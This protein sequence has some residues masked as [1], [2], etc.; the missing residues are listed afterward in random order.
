MIFSSFAS[1]IDMKGKRGKT[2]EFKRVG[3]GS[4]NEVNV[5]GWHLKTLGTHIRDEGLEGV[6]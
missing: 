4:K 5:A 2:I 1:I 6:K 3:I